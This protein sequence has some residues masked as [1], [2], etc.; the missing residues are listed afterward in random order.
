MA[1]R[2]RPPSQGSRTFLRNHAD[3]ISSMDLFVVPT[4]SFRLLYIADTSTR[5]PRGL[6]A[7]RPR[8]LYVLREE[9]SW[10]ASLP[11]PRLVVVSN[12]AS[13]PDAAGKGTAGGLAV[14]LREAF[15]A[16]QGLWFGWSGKGAS[17]PASQPRMVDKGRVQVAQKAL[18]SPAIVNSALQPHIQIN[19]A[20]IVGWS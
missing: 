1:K 11:R 15:Q 16:Y 14:A 19:H 9:P 3:G 5:S 7:G 6:F 4:I 8:L 2:R 13:V 12:R 18:L 10:S 17:Q 20:M